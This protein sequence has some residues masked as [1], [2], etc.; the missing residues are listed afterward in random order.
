MFPFPAVY[1]LR[2]NLFQACGSLHVT[3]PHWV[4]RTVARLL[5]VLP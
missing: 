3:L 5:I 2:V 1:Y 4:G